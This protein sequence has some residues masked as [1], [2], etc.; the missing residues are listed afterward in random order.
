MDI[1]DEILVQK[2][3]EG[4]QDSYEILVNRY[5]RSVYNLAYRMTNS[6]PDAQDLAQDTFVRAYK[7][8]EKYNSAYSFKNWILTICSNLTK[9]VFRKR[10]KRRQT[11]EQYMEDEYLEDRKDNINKD[12]FELALKKLAPEIR[13]VLALKY[14]EECSYDEI[15]EILMIGVSAA[16]MRAARGK[17]EL[18]KILSRQPEQKKTN[19]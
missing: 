18:K 1:P 7:N 12:K 4:D 13:A 9:N 6:A 19:R 8:L 10:V 15:A 16:K 14:T 5:E 17:D 2:S 11:E 3:I